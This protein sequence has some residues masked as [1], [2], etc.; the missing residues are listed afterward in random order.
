M[1]R[2]PKSSWP[3]SDFP[4]NLRFERNID[5]FTLSWDWVDT[6]GFKAAGFK[7]FNGNTLVATVTGNSAADIRLAAPD[8]NYTYT[9]A[10][11][12]ANGQLSR[13]SVPGHGRAGGP[14]RPCG[15]F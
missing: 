11:F 8:G 6:A 12:D 4:Y 15:I 14:E 9:V 10:A 1:G 2:R 13:F 3:D 7:V 5:V